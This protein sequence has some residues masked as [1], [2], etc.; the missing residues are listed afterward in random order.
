MTEE[1]KPSKGSEKKRS[2]W[3]YAEVFFGYALLAGGL[4]YIFHDIKFGK[5]L[6]ELGQMKWAWGAASIR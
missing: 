2:A 4:V 1:E 6:S 3:G 5:L